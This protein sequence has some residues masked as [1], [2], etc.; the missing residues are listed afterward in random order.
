M[1]EICDEL[2]PVLQEVGYTETAPFATASLVFRFGNHTSLAPEYSPI[3]R[4]HGELPVAVE[5]CMD[6]LQK[7]DRQEL[8]RL[9][10]C[11][12]LKTLIDIGEKNRL[13]TAPFEARLNACGEEK[14]AF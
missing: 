4:R 7:A 13:P 6:E 11:A 3:D 5:L 2:E 9:L 14:G 1:V 8:K 10:M 12:T